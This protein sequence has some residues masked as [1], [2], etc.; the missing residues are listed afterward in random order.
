MTADFASAAT[1]NSAADGVN[2]SSAG[3]QEARR[4]SRT[5]R[6]RKSVA[7]DE[8]RC[9]IL[10]NHLDATA[11]RALR[12]LSAGGQRQIIDQGP[13]TGTNTSAMLVSRVKRLKDSQAHAALPGYPSS[14]CAVDEDVLSR[15]IDDNELDASAVKALREAPSQIQNHV[16]A[17]GAVTGRNRS[18]ILVG[19]IRRANQAVGHGSD[20]RGVDPAATQLDQFIRDND[21][22][23]YAEKTLRE[24]GR[25]VQAIVISEGS[26]TGDNKSKI[27][28]G[29]IKRAQQQGK[30]VAAAVAPVMPPPMVSFGQSIVPIGGPSPPPP[31]MP[32]PP[33]TEAHLHAAAQAAAAAAVASYYGMPPPQAAMYYPGY[34]PAYSYPAVATAAGMYAQQATAAHAAQVAQA[35]MAAQAAHMQAQAQAQ[36]QAYG[37]HAAYG[38]YAP[39]VAFVPAPPGAPVPAPPGAPG[40]LG[41]NVSVEEFAR[42]NSLD[43]SAI[44]TLREQQLDV[45]QKVISEGFLTGTNKSAV[46]MSRVRRVVEQAKEHFGHVSPAPAQSEDAIGAFARENALDSAAERALR[47]QP[48]TVF[49]RVLDEGPITGLN[50]SAIVI[51]R[52]RRVQQQSV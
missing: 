45:Q 41:S 33:G 12:D 42:Q 35:A 51:S 3:T 28:M 14:G 5:P 27:L 31:M 32:P 22:D 29:R 16:I 6:G 19:R 50:R 25:D 36:A 9:F 38:A 8:L 17:E 24:Q 2:G 46:L 23:P 52:I 11:E 34:F 43:A 44:K 20:S 7:E 47:D 15:F 48:E 21:L 10:T 49:Q 39:A 26:V 30:A 37:L 13:C 40:A 4:R 18:A 1:H